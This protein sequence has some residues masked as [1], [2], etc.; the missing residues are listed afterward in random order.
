MAAPHGVLTRLYRP[1]RKHKAD[2][3]ALRVYL[4][5]PMLTSNGA[6]EI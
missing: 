3:P 5:Y 2:R 1:H 6:W 4:A